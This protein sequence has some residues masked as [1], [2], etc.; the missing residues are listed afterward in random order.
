ML[1][2]VAFPSG[3][4]TAKEIGIA[5]ATLRVY[6]NNNILEVDKN[7]SPMKYRVIPTTADLNSIFNTYPNASFV[8]VHA[9]NFITSVKRKNNAMVVLLDALDDKGEL[10]TAPFIISPYIK[11][12]NVYGEGQPFSINLSL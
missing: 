8:L 4:F 7:C 3:W 2:S 10:Q 6:V 1:K 5:A 12:I 9:D 11:Y